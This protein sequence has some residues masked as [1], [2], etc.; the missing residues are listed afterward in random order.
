M[1]EWILVVM[2][3]LSLCTSVLYD[4]KFSFIYV[5]LLPLVLLAFYFS[6]FEIV[7]TLLFFIFG[8]IGIF[9][10]LVKLSSSDDKKLNKYAPSLLPLFIFSIIV[11]FAL[12]D[13]Y[14]TVIDPMYWSDGGIGMSNR[15]AYGFIGDNSWSIEKYKNA[16]ELSM[17]ISFSLFVF[18]I[19]LFI[20]DQKRIRRASR[21]FSKKN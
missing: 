19:I 3:I 8:F 5:I 11:C 2:I 21:F 1:I 14:S 15:L 17:Y 18:Y 4:K 12:W 13:N 9:A 20:I 16:F 7:T 6:D 10:A